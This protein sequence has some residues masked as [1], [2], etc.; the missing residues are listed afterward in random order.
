MQSQASFHHDE[1]LKKLR[2][3]RTRKTE[4]YNVFDADFVSRAEW[5]EFVNF[6]NRLNFDITSGTEASFLYNLLTLRVMWT[7]IFSKTTEILS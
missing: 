3:T 5:N 4:N 2:W 1:L 7:R 6:C